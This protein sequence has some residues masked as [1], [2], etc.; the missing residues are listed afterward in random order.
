MP[1]EN[2]D[3]IELEQALEA[4]ADELRTAEEAQALL[5]L[6]PAVRETITHAWQ[7]AT[8]DARIEHEQYG[9]FREAELSRNEQIARNLTGPPLKRRYAAGHGQSCGTVYCWDPARFGDQPGL[10]HAQALPPQHGLVRYSGHFAWGYVGDAPQ[11][12]ALAILAEY[13]GDPSTALRH[14]GAFMREIVARRPI[15]ADFVIDDDEIDAWL[16]PRLVEPPASY[17]RTI[18]D[19]AGAPGGS[20]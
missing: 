7:A 9:R 14:S 2:P 5:R 16:Q 1:A 6:L 11:Q 19:E 13:T 4:L 18:A 20:T 17:E 8:T 12:L 15:D 10:G 3:D